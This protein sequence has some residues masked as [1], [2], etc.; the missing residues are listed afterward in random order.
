[1]DQNETLN[2]L[3]KER[4]NSLPYNNTHQAFE[5]NSNPAEH[6]QDDVRQN[7]RNLVKNS[8][9]RRNKSIGKVQNSSTIKAHAG[10]LNK[11]LDGQNMDESSNQD[12]KKK[13]NKKKKGFLSKLFTLDFKDKDKEGKDSKERKTKKSSKSGKSKNSSD[14]TAVEGDEPPKRT[15]IFNAEGVEKSMDELTISELG[16]LNPKLALAE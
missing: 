4:R 10:T 1:M 7:Q 15:N 9:L 11:H 16:V 6:L 8:V 3:K 13:K 5:Q 2:K 14:K 12:S